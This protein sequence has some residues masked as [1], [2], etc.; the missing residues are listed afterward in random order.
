MC[1]LQ[2][3]IGFACPASLPSCAKMLEFPELFGV[4]ECAYV[5][6][7]GGQLVTRGGR[8]AQIAAF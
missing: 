2:R 1:G 6:C 3:L 7:A 8:G 5:A 4:C